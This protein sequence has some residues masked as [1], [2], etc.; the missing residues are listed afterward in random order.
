MN[1]KM[2]EVRDR[3]ESVEGELRE[4]QGC[5]TG[6]DFALIGKLFMEKQK[7]EGELKVF[8]FFFFF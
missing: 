6:Q 4:A 7:I 1:D 5:S 3:L 8:F 2:R